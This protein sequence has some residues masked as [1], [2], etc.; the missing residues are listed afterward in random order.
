MT[1]MLISINSGV[2]PGTPSV[3]APNGLTRDNLLTDLRE[4]RERVSKLERVRLK[5][6]SLYMLVSPMMNRTTT[7]L[8]TL[9]ARHSPE[10]ALSQS[11]LTMYEGD[12]RSDGKCKGY[13]EALSNVAVGLNR[14]VD[15]GEPI[16]DLY[17]YNRELLTIADDIELHV[18]GYKTFACDALPY[19]LDCQELVV[20]ML[21][22]MKHPTKIDA[23]RLRLNNI[24][25]GMRQ[26]N[27]DELRKHE[28]DLLSIKA[29]T[30]LVAACKI[31]L[32]WTEAR[33]LQQED[34]DIQVRV[35]WLF[36]MGCLGIIVASLVLSTAGNFMLTLKETS[37]LLN[38]PWCVLVW[39]LI[40]CIAAM[41]RR[42][43]NHPVYVTEDLMKFLLGRPAQAM[44]IGIIFWQ[45][46]KSGLLPIQVK[47][48]AELP[49]ILLLSFLIGFSDRF[50]EYVLG[51]LVE[52]YAGGKKPADPTE[53]PKN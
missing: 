33:Q 19:V 2:T 44:V 23:A 12:L 39:I 25:E 34:I 11:P 5:L 4:L 1:Q 37:S 36:Y 9:D 13:L 40:G 26:L 31:Q 15:S 16:T 30:M 41:L 21:R 27:V 8:Q 28:T 7:L 43:N 46:Y 50:T 22:K 3:A 49:L 29:E 45:I 14:L 42:F 48:E 10:T 38:L 47:G 35:N 51:S 24:K 6:L 53:Q 52:K 17:T 18:Q 20:I 32:A